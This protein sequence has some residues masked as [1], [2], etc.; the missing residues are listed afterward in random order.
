VGLFTSPHL[1][2]F[3]ERIKVNL[4][5]VSDEKLNRAFLSVKKLIEKFGLTYFEASLILA[6]EIFRKER[7]DAAVFE[8][9]LG[10]RL[11]ATNALNHDLAVLTNVQIDHTNFLGFS[12]FEI[13]QEKAEIFR[14][15][16]LGVVGTEDER[17][18]KAVSERFNGEP[19][20][21]GKDFWADGIS[22]SLEG[23]NFFYMGSLPVKLKLIGEVQAVNASVAIR[24]AQVFYEKF[25]GH[26]TI[27]REFE[28]KIP[29]RFEILKR[30]PI[31]VFDVAHNGG[32]L[33]E[34]FKTA[35]K[36][37]LK[38]NVY[39][40]SLRDKNLTENL[41]IVGDYLKKS[42]GELYLLG[43]KGKRGMPADELKKLTDSLGLKAE[44]VE[45]IKLSRLNSPAI[46]TGSF[47]IGDLI[48]RD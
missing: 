8:V 17:V 21:C 37:S 47:Y 27:P 7:V 32:A 40:G 10:G 18:L 20:I 33:R 2:R 24:A 45:K 23:T 34:L 16:P 13:A 19:S 3:N 43:T 35:L 11:D 29:G 28:V 6:L 31:V 14:K 12:V 36:L 44:A 39:Y 1:Y 22:V 46:I 25:F 26:F 4:K 38:A 5:E 30:N 15:V 42:G 9:G 41:S 48:E